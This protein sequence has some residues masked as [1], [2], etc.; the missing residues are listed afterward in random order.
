LGGFIR[1]NFISGWKYGEKEVVAVRR[2][3][4]AAA[5]SREKNRQPLIRKNKSMNRKG[6]ER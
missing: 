3:F 4:A 1:G 5:L 6:K 2:K